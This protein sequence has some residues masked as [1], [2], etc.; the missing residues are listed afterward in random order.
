MGDE[1]AQGCPE[2]FLAGLSTW[3]WPHGLGLSRTPKAGRDS[4]QGLGP[5]G[6]PSG[7]VAFLAP[8]VPP[9]AI[10]WVVEVIKDPL[11][12]VGVRSPWASRLLGLGYPQGWGGRSCAAR[13]LRRPQSPS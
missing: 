5:G 10:L 12:R 3:R 7:S 9:C 1:K 2:S 6:A 8:S 11:C 4:C 13:G